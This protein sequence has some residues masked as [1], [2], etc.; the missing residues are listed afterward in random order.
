M[1]NRVLSE[2]F[3]A[4]CI[5]RLA[6]NLRA[7]EF[8][9]TVCPHMGLVYVSA[10]AQLKCGLCHEHHP[11]LKITRDELKMLANG[12]LPE[13]VTHHIDNI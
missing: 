8:Y 1:A 6:M 3:K 12:E 5:D 13:N 4:T 7:S 9:L 11:S 2:K 10:G